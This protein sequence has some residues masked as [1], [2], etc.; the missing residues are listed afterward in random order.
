[1]SDRP[2][3]LAMTEPGA[4][5]IAALRRLPCLDGVGE[6]RL[7]ALASA[8]RWQVLAPGQTIVD[9]GD[10]GAEV[11][12]VT[13]GRVRV[14]VRSAEGHEVI[15]NDLDAGEHFGELAAIDGACR[16]AT[17]TALSRARIC[18]VPG[19][20]FLDAVLA[21]PAAGLRLL[22]LL[23]ARGRLKDQRT[24]E[25]AALPTRQR[26]IAELLRMSSPRGDGERRITPPP[27]QQVIA[28]RLGLR[29][30]TVSRE[31]AR[32]ARDSLVSVRRGA[33]IL[34]DAEALKAE[35]DALLSLD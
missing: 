27:P 35:L 14:V 8:A 31:L 17:V 3:S 2:A 25:A 28:A 22:R 13:E 19:R 32:L 15:L 18:A 7:Q 16:S 12:F 29:R 26:L 5:G 9:A 24:L 10:R 23:A 20:V 11:F 21:T 33:I 6:D 30:E 1:M 34:H 4:A